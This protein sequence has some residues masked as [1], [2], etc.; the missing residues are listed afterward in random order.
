MT[1][2]SR[3]IALLSILPAATQRQG[4]AS[5]E[6]RSCLVIVEKCRLSWHESVVR[7]E[8]TSLLVSKF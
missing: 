5:Q 4:K 7:S 2:C 1:A 3:A 8:A 6:L